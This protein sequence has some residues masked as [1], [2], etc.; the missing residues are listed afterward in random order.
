MTDIT[1]IPLNRLTAWEGNVR[2]TQSRGFIEELAASIKAHGLQQNLVVKKHGREFA[3][4]AGGQRLKALRL[5]AE[6][7]DIESSH[8]VACRIA[9]GEIDAT[10]LSLAENVVRDQM[11]PADQF[12]AFRLLIDK[13][14][15]VE[16]IAARF[17][18]TAAVVTQRLKLGRV[19]SVVLQA[20]REER[21][22][23]EDV[24][25]FTVS[26]D[27]AA[28]ERVSA[29]LG[30]WQGAQEIRAALTGSDVPATD[31]RVRFVTLTSYEA[32]GGATRR[33]L[34][35]EGDDGIFVTDA[36]LLDELVVE[37]LER[38]AQPVRA[39]GWKWVEIRPSFGYEERSAFHRHHPE[40]EPLSAEH[41]MR[42]EDLQREYDSILKL[43]ESSDD[44]APRPA[45]LNE[46]EEEIDRLDNRPEMWL[47]E[48]LA[49]AGAVVTI[50]HNGEISVE[51]GLVRAEDMPKTVKGK[52][53]DCE[54]G[55]E[56][57]PQRPR[58]S[59]ALMESLSAERSAALAAELVRRP[60]VALAAVVHALALPIVFGGP[61]ATCLKIAAFPQSLDRVEG[62]RAFVAVEE[63]RQ[64]WSSDLPV[65]PDALWIWC[66]EQEQSVLLD[67]LAFCCATTVNA[68]QLKK[69]TQEDARLGHA[70]ML[71]S[72]LRLDM[73][74][75]FT[76]T[77]TNYFGRVSKE[78]I[79][80]ALRE[81]RNAPPAP[82]WEKLP[83]SALATLAEREIAGTPWLPL[84]LR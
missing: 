71:A 63:R 31:K 65:T 49:I 24:M 83:K 54:A 8:P 72:A 74:A 45:R 10:E 13:G 41:A 66:L 68:V 51:R 36:A 6:A 23:L 15:P 33:D 58:F 84:P 44:E 75:W 73:A 28:Q 5:L 30:D 57:G 16:D 18:V 70:A 81:A 9:K 76:P 67:L 40:L 26:D 3:V 80:D 46:I 43:W 64:H 52:N 12:E 79:L 17:G 47:P 56:T 2:K 53:P 38:A 62:S 27:H 48:T 59:S 32:A 11:H 7:G 20:Y 60:D 21:L 1:N 22:T 50:G 14:T 34:F 69:D 29:M 61:E 77:A 37:R 35:T 25:A 42:L 19:S 55:T 82:A 78:Q 4:I 39:E